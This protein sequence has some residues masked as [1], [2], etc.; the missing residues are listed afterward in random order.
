M[1]MPK[2]VPF[3]DVDLYDFAGCGRGYG[4]DSFL[5]FEFDDRLIPN[6]AI[7]GADED[8]CHRAGLGVFSQIWQAYFHGL[9]HTVNGKSFS[10][11]TSS[12]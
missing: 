4:C 10:G 5:A 7:A 2:L 11:S 1:G 8:R 6:D 12:S 3:F 9:P